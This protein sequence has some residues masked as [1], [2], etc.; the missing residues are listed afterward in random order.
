MRMKQWCVYDHSSSK[1]GCINKL[2]KSKKTHKT[3]AEIPVTQGN[4]TRLIKPAWP[5]LHLRIF[6][7]M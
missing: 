2:G 4:K 7:S 6:I 5:S 3:I 1:A